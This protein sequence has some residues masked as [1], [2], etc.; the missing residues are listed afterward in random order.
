MEKKYIVCLSGGHSSAL[1]A[2]EAVR[3]VGKENVILLN[4][5]ISPEVEDADIKRFKNDISNYLDIPITYANMEGWETKTPLRICKEIG[6]FKVGNGSALCTNR[7][8]TVPFYK[9]LAE[10]YSIEKGQMYEGIKILYGF[11]KSEPSRIQRRVGIMQ[12]KGYYTDF[13]L[14]Y[15]NRT[16]EKTE[17]TGIKRPTTYKIYRHANCKGCLKAGRQQWYLTFC[18]NPEIW[19]EAKEAESK[20]G[21]SIL[22]DTYLEE[23]E[24]KFKQMRCRGI[25][26]TEKMKPQ[27]FWAMV[28]KE[29]PPEGQ[30][31]FLPC[32]CAL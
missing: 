24:P 17:D 29:L 28:K 23:L 4:H 13:P 11:D 12:I 31:T 2:I 8:K 7:L 6:A 9:W 10:N 14:A 16:I 30:M 32:E 1:V 18:L 27:T 21:Y 22:K 25:I 3:K 5:D 26:P 20:I 15:W 19:E